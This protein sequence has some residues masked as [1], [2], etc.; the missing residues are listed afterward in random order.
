MV[1]NKNMSNVHPH[2][3]MGRANDT[4]FEVI[5]KLNMITC[6]GLVVK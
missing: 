2:E 1:S 3:F 5:K 6:K 4:H